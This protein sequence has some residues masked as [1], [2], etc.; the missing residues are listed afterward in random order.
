MAGTWIKVEKNT[1]EKP[2]VY[3]IAAALNIDPDLAFAKCFK[4]W[5]WAD[6]HTT[7]GN[8]TSVTE[9]LL[10][11]ITGVKGFAVA[12]EKV[13]WL[14]VNKRGDS[15]AIFGIEIPNFERH[16][17]EGAKQRALTANR[18]EKSRAKKKP[19]K[20]SDPVTIDPLPEKRRE[21][22]NIEDTPLTP[23]RGEGDAQPQAKPSFEQ[24]AEGLSTAWVFYQTRRRNRGKADTSDDAMP[25]FLEILRRGASAA[26][27]LADIES[28]ERDRTEYLWQI[29]NRYLSGAAANGA[30]GP[31]RGKTRTSKDV[32]DIF[33][34]DKD[35]R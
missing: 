30:Q 32:H 33:L 25:Y 7:N 11:S 3:A 6:D 18:V 9:F 20:Q 5:R 2:E 10:D 15:A 1:P 26:A 4:L 14:I 22:K 28:P 31:Q 19:G 16:M 35:C 17:G 12:L 27:V 24:T 13:G 34:N 23:Q 8:A 21:E 29:K